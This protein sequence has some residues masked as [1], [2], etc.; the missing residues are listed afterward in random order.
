MNQ[1]EGLSRVVA[2]K[3]NAGEVADADVDRHL[4]A[5]HGAAQH[6]AFAMK[7]D[8]SCVPIGAR[9]VRIEADRKGKWVEPQ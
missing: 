5:A 6:D 1:H 2:A 3:R 8:L 7:L 9:I 4:H